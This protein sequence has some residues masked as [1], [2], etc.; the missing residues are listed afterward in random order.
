MARILMMQ[1]MEVPCAVLVLVVECCMYVIYTY[2]VGYLLICIYISYLFL[3]SYQ[4]KDVKG[5]EEFHVF[6]PCPSLSQVLLHCDV[7]KVESLKLPPVVV[8]AKVAVIAVAFPAALPM[9]GIP[10]ECQVLKSLVGRDLQ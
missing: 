4:I 1:Q 8:I 3:F 10:M 5:R 7:C 2:F 6:I 9:A